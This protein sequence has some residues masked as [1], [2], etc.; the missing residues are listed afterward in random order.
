MHDLASRRKDTHYDV[1]SRLRPN[2]NRCEQE[3]YPDR[4]DHNAHVADRLVPRNGTSLQVIAENLG[5]LRWC[6]GL[7]V[8]LILHLSVP[9]IEQLVQIG[10]VGS[11]Y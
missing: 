2:N 6:V 10:I 7:L 5:A 3:D 11:V 8:I 4:N 1:L 9:G